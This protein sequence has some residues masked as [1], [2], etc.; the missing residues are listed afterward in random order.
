MS[1]SVADPFVIPED[2]VLTSVGALP[3]TLRSELD[4]E[5]GDFAVTRPHSRT[6]SR[7]VDASTADLLRQFTEAKPI[8]EAIIAF[9]RAAGSDPEKTTNDATRER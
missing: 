6:P 1:F 9:S 3:P 8:T 2:I 7:V 5:D 4:C